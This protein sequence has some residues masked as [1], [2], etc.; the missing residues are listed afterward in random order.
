MVL[1]GTRQRSRGFTLIELLVVIAIIAILAAMLLPALAKAKN[2][3]AN[4]NCMNNLNQVQKACVMFTLDNLD[5]LPPNPDDGNTTAGNN[6]CGGQAGGWMPS[7]TSG[8]SM[9][10]GNPQFTT[11]DRWSLL[12][13]Y[14]GK[15]GSVFQCPRDPRRCPYSGTDPS[16]VGKPIKV[17]RS[18]SLNQGVGTDPRLGPNK[19]TNGPWLDG[20]H[21]HQADTPYATFGKMTDFIAASPSEIWTFADDDPWTINDAAIA[22]IAA[23]PDTVDYVS[24]MHDNGCGF[25]FADGHSEVH[26]W[27]SSIWMHP[28]G[29][30][31][32][33]A[34][35]AGAATGLGRLDWYWFAWHATRNTRTRNVP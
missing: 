27:K 1:G 5:Y 30:V 6:W 7:I 31:S 18:I 28:G 19:K 8:G 15:S 29:N 3:A 24:P 34:F 33:S 21:T 22:V 35:Q 11:D 32:R 14:L 23:Q 17:I 26:K 25:A 4:L 13:P 10:A 12:A 20:N 16:Q 2:K 9:D